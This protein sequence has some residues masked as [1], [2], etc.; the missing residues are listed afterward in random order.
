MKKYLLLLALVGLSA[1][2]IAAQQL[3]E[4][5]LADAITYALENN[6]TAKN[7]RLELLISKA[8]IK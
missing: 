5:K 6:P 3:V 8:T 2:Q 1:S 7:A 4:L